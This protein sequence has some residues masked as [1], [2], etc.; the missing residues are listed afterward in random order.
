MLLSTFEKAEDITTKKN[1]LT[2]YLSRKKKETLIA[3]RVCNVFIFEIENQP[4]E[5]TETHLQELNR[6]KKKNNKTESKFL[7]QNI[8]IFNKIK[9]KEK[10]DLIHNSVSSLINEDF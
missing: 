4:V 8:S 3:S 10:I 5:Q 6:Q 9:K 2:C 1:I 7:R